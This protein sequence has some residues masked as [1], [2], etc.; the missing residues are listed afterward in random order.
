LALSVYYSATLQV[1]SRA[2][3]SSALPDYSTAHPIQVAWCSRNSNA[4]RSR[5][6]SAALYNMTV[7]AGGIIAANIYRTDDAPRYKRGDRVLVAL[8]ATNIA[9]YFLTK[10][11]YVLRNRYKAR[12]WDAMTED[13]RLVYLKT[14]AD[15]GNKRLDFRF[16]H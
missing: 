11:Y 3:L 5:T 13:E 7:Q 16:A 4:V 15:E 8:G 1:I 2:L 14:T 10:I 6:V 9:V 12:K